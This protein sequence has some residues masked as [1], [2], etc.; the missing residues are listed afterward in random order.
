MIYRNRRHARNGGGLGGKRKT[1]RQEKVSSV[2]ANPELLENIKEAVA[3]THSVQSYLLNVYG[4][5]VKS[6]P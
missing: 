2:E 1:S 4:L 5:L 6:D 3:E